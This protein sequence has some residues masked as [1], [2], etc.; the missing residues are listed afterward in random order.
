MKLPFDVPD[1]LLTQGTSCL[2]QW[3]RPPTK[4]YSLKPT[5]TS[6]FD[7][8]STMP[9]RFLTEQIVLLER[10]GSQPLNTQTSL[11]RFRS[12]I[13]RFFAIAVS[14]NLHRSTSFADWTSNV[15]WGLTVVLFEDIW[16]LFYHGKHISPHSWIY[17]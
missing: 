11:T 1:C 6:L 8:S 2:E 10:H 9:I 5:A 16:P 14:W 15:Q 12:N 17:L 7:Q 4:T 13:S 3:R